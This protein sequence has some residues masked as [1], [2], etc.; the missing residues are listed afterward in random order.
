MLDYPIV[1]WYLNFM[2]NNINDKEIANWVNECPTH[3]IEVLYS[4]ENGIQLLVNF[5]NEKEENN[6]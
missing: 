6:E 4:D 1:K 5:N 2:Q 3:K